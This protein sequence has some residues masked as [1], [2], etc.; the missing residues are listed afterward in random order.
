M[1]IRLLV[2]GD[3]AC[4]K[5]IEFAEDL[6]TL[7]FD[8]FDRCRPVL[9]LGQ[10]GGKRQR[11]QGQQVAEAGHVGFLSGAVSKGSMARARLAWDNSPRWLLIRRPSAR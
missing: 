2:Q 10:G 6:G 1:E 3:R 4:F 5:R 7:G 11:Q 9:G 8:L